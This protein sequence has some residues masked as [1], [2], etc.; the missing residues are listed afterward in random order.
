MAGNYGLGGGISN[1]STNAVTTLQ[2]CTFTGNTARGGS[3]GRNLF[4][5]KGGDAGGGQG[6]AINALQGSLTMTNCTLTTNKAE[7]GSAGSGSPAGNPG[8]SFGGGVE[9]SSVTPTGPIGNT[10]I[11]GN[12]SAFVS[13]DVDGIFKSVGFNL[14][15]DRTNDESSFT[16][17]G[18]KT[19]TAAAPLDPKFGAFG[20]N[21]G[22]TDTV[23]L[24]TGSP[25]IN[26]G[27]DSI[28]PATDQRGSS[29]RRK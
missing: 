28:A 13:P 14:V 21:G 15:G 20:N 26:A 12:T 29:R 25:A 18:D 6:G 27:N 23:A 8:Q 3:G 11:A 1:G 17:P 7:N 9:G 16:Q 5:G 24:L 10:I 22:P 2:N 19:G 4:G